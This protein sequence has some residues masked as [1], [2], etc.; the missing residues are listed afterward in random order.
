MRKIFLTLIGSTMI[1]LGALQAQQE[2]DTTGTASESRTKQRKQY[3]QSRQQRDQMRQQRDQTRQQRD[4]TAQQR[5]QT[6]QHRDQ[7]QQQS[8]RS[9]QGN[10]YA[11]EGMVIIEKDKIPSSL[12]QTLQDEKYAGW[13]K[14]TVYYNTSTGEYLIV[15]RPMRFDRQGKEKEMD[16]SMMGYGHRQGQHSQGQQNQQ[17]QSSQYGQQN[18]QGQSSQYG[19]QNQQGQSSQYGQNQQG[20]STQPGQQSQSQSGQYGDRTQDSQTAQERARN[21]MGEVPTSAPDQDN[22]DRQTG[23]Q[24]P[25]TGYRTDQNKQ[26]DAT[27]QNGQSSQQ[28]KTEDMVEIQAEQIPATLRR[29]LSETE[30]RGWEEKGKLYQDPTTNEYVLVIEESD[31][32]SQPRAYHFDANGRLKEDQASQNNSDKNKSYNNKKSNKQ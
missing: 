19:Q 18:Q 29:T 15:P 11:Y 17:G 20:Q 10:T 16:D 32:T 13:E 1:S 27:S 7:S 24:E 23:Q 21:Q 8:D 3:E 9:Q 5:D 30:Y 12:K 6:S 22:Q 4:Q 28:Y 14:A 25:S 2:T 31:N 26:S